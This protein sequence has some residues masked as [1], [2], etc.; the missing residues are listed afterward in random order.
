M[1]TS[2]DYW[3]LARQYM[4][5]GVITYEQCKIIARV[6]H[7]KQNYWDRHILD[8]KRTVAKFRELKGEANDQEERERGE[9]SRSMEP[10]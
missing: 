6:G 7:R 1:A 4:A 2:T 3:T 10:A 8:L 5:E 9:G